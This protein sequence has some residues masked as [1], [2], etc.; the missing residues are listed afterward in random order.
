[1]AA[2]PPGIIV[3]SPG[4]IPRLPAREGEQESGAGDNDGDP[5]RSEADRIDVERSE[6][7]RTEATDED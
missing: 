2:T 7:E 3:V 1:V 4:E 5:E 6:A